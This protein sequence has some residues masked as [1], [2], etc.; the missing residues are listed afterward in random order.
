MEDKFIKIKEQLINNLKEKFIQTNASY[1][2][3]NKIY[4]VIGEQELKEFFDY[5]E[6]VWKENV[7]I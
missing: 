3:N 1:W 4:F 6:K 2:K 7:E 5:L